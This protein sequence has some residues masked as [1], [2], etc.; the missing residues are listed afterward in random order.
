MG[1]PDDLSSMWNDAL[2]RADALL[3]RSKELVVA[4]RKV[5]GGTWLPFS[6]QPR[7]QNRKLAPQRS[8][9]ARSG[10]NR[11]VPIGPFVVSTYASISATCPSSCTFKDH[12]CYAQ[13][14]TEHLTMGRLDRSARGLSALEVSLAEADGLARLWIRGVPQDGAK[15]GRDLRIHVGGDV[16]CKA[17]ARALADAVEG[18]QG[19][20]LGAAF[21]MTH[22][23]RTVPREAWGPI[24]VLASVERTVDIVEA[25]RRGYAPA[26]TVAEFTQTAPFRAHGVRMIPCP[27][28]TSPKAPSCN[29]CRL[30]LRDLA[31]TGEG[32]MFVAHGNE[33]ASVRRR[34]NVLQSQQW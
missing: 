14:N 9:K 11:N 34:L 17:G 22:R 18:L 27:F 32:I 31:A 10:R 13:A 25:N 28:E 8:E 7:S 5:R 12:G 19:R 33:V 15:G 2:A 21:S 6:I 29:E 24:H 26:L 30:C 23:W 16:S 20:G 4:A 1:H 3:E